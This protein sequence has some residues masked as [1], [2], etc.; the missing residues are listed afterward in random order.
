MFTVSG[1]QPYEFYG[2]VVRWDESTWTALQQTE[3]QD[4]KELAQE[5]TDA[6]WCERMQT[7]P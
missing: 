5:A 4:T 7:A 1:K 2:A 3:R 6:L